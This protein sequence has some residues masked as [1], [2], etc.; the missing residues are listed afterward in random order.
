[1]GR[2]GSM[3]KRDMLSVL[4]TLKGRYCTRGALATREYEGLVQAMTDEWETFQ[5]CCT[6][7]AVYGK[8]GQA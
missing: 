2:V 6:L 3:L 4:D 8:R 5:S 1:M 7:F